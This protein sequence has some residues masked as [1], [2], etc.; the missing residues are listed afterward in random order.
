MLNTLNTLIENNTPT[1][2]ADIIALFRH[3]MTG[4]S[5]S[6]S[7][8]NG[9]I[10][11][12][13]GEHFADLIVT[14][15][16]KDMTRKFAFASLFN[17]TN[18]FARVCDFETGAAY[19]RAVTALTNYTP[20]LTRAEAAN[21]KAADATKEAFKKYLANEYTVRADEN[22]YRALGWLSKRIT[23]VV[24]TLPKYL[25][26]Q[27]VTKFGTD[28]VY[29]AFDETENYNSWAFKIGVRL[30]AKKQEQVP[31]ALTEYVTLPSRTIT[32]E[33]FILELVSNYGFKLNRQQDTDAIFARIPEAFQ[34]AFTSGL[35]E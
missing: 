6:G 14:V 30:N 11:F 16:F 7:Y 5:V 22:F 27:F 34:E 3:H 1:L 31:E 2:E 35:S 21:A 9:R 17:K 20:T 15:A 28:A 32:D 26:E 10:A 24:V 18:S 4:R 25:E 13:A 33:A 8:G 29:K 23:T 12:F 19:N